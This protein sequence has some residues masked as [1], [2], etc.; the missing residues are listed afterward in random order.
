M[1]FAS[2]SSAFAAESLSF[3]PTSFVILDPDTGTRIG[4]S[5]YRVESIAGGAILHGVNQFDNGQSDIETAR[6]RSGGVDELPRLVEFDHTFYNADRS[7]QERAHV[8]LKSG[9]ASCIDNTGGQQSEQRDVL[10]FPDDTWA[11]ASV[12]LPIQHFLRDDGQTS[13]HSL[14]VFNCAPSPK[15][16]AISVQNDPGP[17]TWAPYGGLA[18]RVEVKPDFGWLNLLIAAF[19]PRLH[20]W[21]DPGA[22]WAFVGDEAARYYKGSKIMLVRA[23]IESHRA[24]RRIK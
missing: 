6:L 16:F 3:P 12:V 21:F 24:E 20:A 22:D 11:G 23:R 14:H 15:I 17:A 4:S 19:V 2:G 13:S 7:I 1:L 9:A 5:H 8:D 18:L 10:S